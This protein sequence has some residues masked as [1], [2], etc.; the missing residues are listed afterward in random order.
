MISDVLED[1]AE[2]EVR[3]WGPVKRTLYEFVRV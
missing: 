2:V 1:G 3:K